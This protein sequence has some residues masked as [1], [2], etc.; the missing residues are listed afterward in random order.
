MLISRETGSIIL[1]E[2]EKTVQCR[3]QGD[4]RRVEDLFSKD[5]S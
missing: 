4:I 5:L 1:I 2:N 3:I